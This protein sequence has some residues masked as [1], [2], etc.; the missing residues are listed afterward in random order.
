[1]VSFSIGI[2]GNR[3]G[4]MRPANEVAEDIA[5]DDAARTSSLINRAEVRRKLIQE[6]RDARYYWKQFEPRVSEA[7]LALIERATLDAIRNHVS[8]LPS[9][10]KTI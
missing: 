5:R 10:G 3:K 9:K 6:A 4:K 8:K 7:T 2:A 1:M